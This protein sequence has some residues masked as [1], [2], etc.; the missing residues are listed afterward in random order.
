MARCG[1][2]EPSFEQAAEG[3][4]EATGGQVSGASVRRVTQGFGRQVRQRQA[5]ETKQAAETGPFAEVPQD[6]WLELHTPLG[7]AGNVSSDGTMILVREEG[8]QEVKVAA[9]SEVASLPPGHPNGRKAQRAGE[10]E[11]ESLV[12]LSAHSYCAGLWD[13]DTF[14]RY[15]Y[16]EGLRRGFDRVSPS[17]FGERRGAVDRPDHRHQLPLCAVDCGLE[18]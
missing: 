4:R 15:Q 7:E 18:S 11:H 8:W 1:L 3:Y 13:A 2:R 14:G 16:V 17:Q 10:R 9:F 12:R 5:Q 6:R